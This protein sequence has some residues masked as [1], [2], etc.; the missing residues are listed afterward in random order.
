MGRRSDHSR[1]EL[2]A[3]ALKAAQR[4]AE[5]EG[6]RGLTT[7]RIAQEIGYTVGTLYNVFE[8][9]DDLIVHLNSSTLD[10]LFQSCSKV[11]LDKPPEAAVRSLAE[12]Y[13]RFI[14]EHPKLWS[15][16]FEHHLPDDAELPETYNEKVRRLLAL[17][18]Q[19]LAPLFAPDQ[20][21]E[22]KHS[23][24]VLWSSLYGI[25]SLESAA[26]LGKNVS[27]E[28]LTDSMVTNYLAGLRART[29]PRGRPKSALARASR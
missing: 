7:R 3:L 1:K 26:K 23:A 17:L 16:L 20:D 11:K 6:L 5:E 8:N 19:A 2:Y 12:C 10:A 18:E 21:A 27:V 14:R 9:L 28:A 24:R 22:R 25:C 29:R 13:I 15:V 4:I